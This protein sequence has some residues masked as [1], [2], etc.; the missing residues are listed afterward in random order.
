MGLE[1]THSCTV[2]SNVATQEASEVTFVASSI[3]NA[4]LRYGDNE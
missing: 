2:D 3:A 4:R 1:P